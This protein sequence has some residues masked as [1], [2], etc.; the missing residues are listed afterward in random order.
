MESTQPTCRSVL[1][2]GAMLLLCA[3]LAQPA[4]TLAQGTGAV[5]GTV[6]TREDGRTLSAAIVSVRGTSL[7]AV[8][9]GEGNYRITGVPAGTVYIETSYIGRR[10]GGRSVEVRAGATVRADIELDVHPLSAQALVITATR[11]VAR[12]AETPASVG[13]VTRA[14]IDEARPTHPSEIMNRVPGVW[15][16]VTG[17]EGHMAAIRQPKTTNPVYLYLE[18]GV[19]TR[20]TGFFNHNA[21]YEINLPQA[22]RIEVIKGPASALYGSDAIG[23]LVNLTTRAPSQDAEVSAS[24]EGGSYGFARLLLSASGTQGRNGLRA[25]LNLTRTD[26]WR[27]G[28]AYDR[29]SGTIRWDHDFGSAK[30]RTVAA[31]SRIDQSTAGSS[32]ISRDDY[33]NDPTANYTPISFRRIHAFRFSTAYERLGRSSL[34]S[35]TPFARWNRM[36]ILPNWS[37]TFD[38]GVWDTGHASIGALV[39]YRHDFAPLRTRIIAGADIEHSPGWHEE[40]SIQAMRNGN[41]FESYEPGMQIYDYDVTFRGISP[42]MQLET[43]PHEMVRITAGLRSDHLSYGYDNALGELRTGAHRRPASTSVSYD[44]WSPKLGITVAPTADLGFFAAYSHGFRAPSEGQL[45]R[46]GRASSTIDLFPVKVDQLEAGVRGNIAFLRYDLAVYDLRKTDDILSLTNPDGTT[47]N[48]NAGETLHRGVE[49]GLGTDLPHGFGLDV[50][51][52]RAKH[53][54]EEW[55]PRAGVDFSGNEQEDAPNT[56]ANVTLHW[57]RP[58]GGPAVALEFSRI[59]QYWMDADNTTRYPGH[60][61]LNLRASVPVVGSITLFGRLSNVLDERYAENAAFTMARGEEY[62]PGLPRTL[63][64]GIQYR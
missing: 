22:D 24:V 26:G 29:Q 30:L 34:L 42:W 5:E 23:G 55:S 3:L 6:R 40:E 31:F 46:Q 63:Y 36:E 33:L 4:S 56:L 39:K 62:A 50:A 16:N 2:H 57:S 14:D 48:V 20:S 7:I 64:I 53:T 21:L 18:D 43:S 19:P 59:G 15:V 8:T 13:V 51:Y 41:V 45:F 32:A 10:A 28:T 35:I 12:R 54:Y 47:E 9:D 52:S 27:S 37:L 58:G 38:P 61:L 1:M 17:G 60:N 49:I 25:D 11:E 44:H